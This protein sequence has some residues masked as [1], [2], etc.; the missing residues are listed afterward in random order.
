MIENLTIEV[1]DVPAAD[2]FYQALV[3]GAESFIDP[4]GFVWVA[5]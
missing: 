2:A 1:D 3:G 5:A 4:D